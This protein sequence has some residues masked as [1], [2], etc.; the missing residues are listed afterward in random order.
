MLKEDILKEEKDEYLIERMGGF[1]V[2]P[3]DDDELIEED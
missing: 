1:D 3:E 2:L